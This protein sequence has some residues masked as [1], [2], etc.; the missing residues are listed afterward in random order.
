MCEIMEKFLSVREIQEALGISRTTAYAL[1]NRTDFPSTNIGKRIV[2]S[3]VALRE[4][5]AN[6]GTKENDDR[7]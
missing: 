1:V 7:R 4:W 6:G 5:L 3:E 2:V